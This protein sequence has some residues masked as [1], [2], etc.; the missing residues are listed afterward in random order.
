MHYGPIPTFKLA[1]S[2][3][4]IH[5][6]DFSGDLYGKKVDVEICK[7]IRNIQTFSTLEA[8][9]NQIATDVAFVREYERSIFDR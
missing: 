5:L 9:K 2:H 4:E 6:L 3:I 8:L 1:E 7:K